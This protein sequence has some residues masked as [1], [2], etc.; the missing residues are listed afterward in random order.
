MIR[1]CNP[2]CITALRGYPDL[3]STHPGNSHL[4]SPLFQNKEGTV[5]DGCVQ[6][7]RT[8]YFHSSRSFVFTRQK[9]NNTD[10]HYYSPASS[11]GSWAI[12]EGT[13]DASEYEAA[14]TMGQGAF[15]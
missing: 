1:A 13:S 15:T 4:F 10:Y 14:L 2:A 9:V 8:T 5:R 7:T 3:V 6:I 11:G 12:D